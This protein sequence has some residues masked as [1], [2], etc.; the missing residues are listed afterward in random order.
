METQTIELLTQ[1]L[2]I[3]TKLNGDIGCICIMLVVIV[4]LLICRN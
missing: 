4:I 2:E 3:L 1:I